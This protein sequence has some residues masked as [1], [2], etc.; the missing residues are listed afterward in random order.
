MIIRFFCSRLL[1][2][3]LLLLPVIAFAAAPAWQINSSQ[4][5]VTF[6]ATQNNAPV[7]GSFK[8]VTGTINFDPKQLNS[9]N[10]TIT[11][12]MN[13]VDSSYAQVADT[14][15]STEWFDV[16]DFPHAIFKTTS[17]TQAGDDTYQVKGMLT[18][19]DKTQPVIFIVKLEKFTTDSAKATGSTTLKRSMFGVGQGEWA[20]TDQ[21]KDDVTVNFT[22]SAVK[23]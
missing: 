4:S 14:L 17:F 11:V 18:I 22:L 7:K 13:S 20:S 12:D 5:S 19:R 8:S 15:K 3:S 23:K 6:T 2:L 16:K 10:A 9:S 1:A 21:I